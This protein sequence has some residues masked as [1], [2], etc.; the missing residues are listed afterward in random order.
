MYNESWKHYINSIKPLLL[1][2]ISQAARIIRDTNNSSMCKLTNISN[3][4]C[5]TQ[6]P[7]SLSAI[8]TRP[9]S[10]LAVAFDQSNSTSATA[11]QSND[12]H[13]NGKTKLVTPAEPLDAAVN[14]EMA[15]HNEHLPSKYMLPP[16]EFQVPEII[17]AQTEAAEIFENFIDELEPIHSEDA[18]DICS[19][20]TSF[21]A[22]LQKLI[23][24]TQQL[25]LA[26]QQ[27]SANLSDFTFSLVKLGMEYGSVDGHLPPVEQKVQLQVENVS[28]RSSSI[29]S[30]PL[31]KRPLPASL[32]RM[33]GSG[34]I[35]EDETSVKKTRFP[36]L[37]D[38]QLEKISKLLAARKKKL[39]FV[40]PQH[41]QVLV[42]S[43]DNKKSDDHHLSESDILISTDFVHKHP[44]NEDIQLNNLKHS[45]TDTSFSALVA[46]LNI[47]TDG[48]CSDLDDMIW[49]EETIR[50]VDDSTA[51]FRNSQQTPPESTIPMNPLVYCHVFV[52][53]PVQRVV[54]QHIVSNIPP[55]FPAR[56][57]I[58]IYSCRHA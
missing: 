33:S 20:Q 5:S 40:T 52:S 50:Q 27:E 34:S 31:K 56:R 12:P 54:H 47:D 15:C 32:L 26:P 18:V 41:T 11:L 42:D 24:G 58:Y 28:C 9:I 21:M 36:S 49:N 16:L 43:M 8:E 1:S 14:Y 19:S 6:V 30:A 3:D 46:D 10:A 23:F 4:N 29:N 53:M 44:T 57:Y 48:M 45:T 38:L 37:N 17:D 7:V 35:K 2:Q 39:Q 22:D 51:T 25:D 55:P 13:D